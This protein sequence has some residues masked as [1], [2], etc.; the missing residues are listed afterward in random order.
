M[1]EKKSM[2]NHIDVILE[3]Y[4]LY[5]ESTDRFSGYRLQAN[6]LFVT[7]NTML[8][9]LLAAV[10]EFIVKPK[11]SWWILFACGTGVLLNIT[12]F[13][14]VRS[15][16]ALN[17]GR[18]KVIR[19]VEEKLPIQ[20]YKM[21]WDILTNQEKSSYIRQSY[22]EQTMPILFGLLY[23]SFGIALIFLP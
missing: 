8:I 1:D 19:T 9:G 5:I 20:L 6:L 14:L 22:V 13:F 21:E 3:Q 17:S 2:T 7:T 15:Y 18:F 4:K 23:I 12:W 11:I 10:L 16:R